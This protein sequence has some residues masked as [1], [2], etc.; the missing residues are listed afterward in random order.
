MVTHTSTG[1]WVASSLRLMIASRSQ[2]GGGQSSPL[3]VLEV[4][5]E[6]P[7]STRVLPMLTLK[8]GPKP[9]KSVDFGLFQENR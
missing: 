8:I 1:A 6:V 9:P 2:V 3:V 5:G 7:K 4:A